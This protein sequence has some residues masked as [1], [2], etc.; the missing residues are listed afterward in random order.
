MVFNELSAETI[1][2]DALSA[3][4]VSGESARIHAGI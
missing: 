4:S 3:A 2:T 1:P